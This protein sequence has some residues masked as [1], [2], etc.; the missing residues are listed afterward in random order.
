MT[1]KSGGADV[2]ALTRQRF[3]SSSGASYY[4]GYVSFAK[5]TSKW[6]MSRVE[7]PNYNS[8]KKRGELLPL[9]QYQKVTESLS[10]AAQWGFRVTYP[11]NGSWSQWKWEPECPYPY[12]FRLSADA[13]FARAGQLIDPHEYVQAAAA[14]IYSSGWD[15]L[16]FIAELKSTQQMF[17][18]IGDSLVALLKRGDFSGTWLQ[19]RYGWRTLYMDMQSLVKAIQSIDDSRKRFRESAG[20]STTVTDVDD[21]VLNWPEGVVRFIQT[22]RYTVGARGVVVADIEPPKISFN[23]VV[24]AWELIRF[25][26]IIDWFINIGQWLAAMSFLTLS[27][28]HFCSAGLHV[29]AARSS[30]F[31]GYKP[32]DAYTSLVANSFQI[33]ND[34]HISNRVPA[35]VP[36]GPTTITRIDVQ[37]IIDLLAL[38]AKLRR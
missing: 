19:Y 4:S 38:V 8:R 27:R 1:V 26:F 3:T 22:T 25:S 28:Q 37:K 5:S 33:Q 20:G 7:T 6:S 14:K 13:C 32:A 2:T 24:T 31:A 12:D 29:H 9:N 16:T 10:F 15:A 18:R 36:L 30:S 21:I 35:S 11:S 34:L 17:L 23:P